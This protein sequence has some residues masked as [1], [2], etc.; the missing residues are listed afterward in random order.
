MDGEV[1]F[2]DPRRR[3]AQE[4]NGERGLEAVDFDI[5]EAAPALVVADN[6]PA[7]IGLA[8]Q[9]V[10]SGLTNCSVIASWVER[11]VYCRLTIR[12]ESDEVT[13]RPCT[14]MTSPSHCCS[15]ARMVNWRAAASSGLLGAKTS[16]WSP[17]PKSGR[18]TRSPGLVMSNC[19][20]MSRT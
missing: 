17:L 20:I 1:V 16:C 2:G 8:F 5:V 11:S 4:E 3:L 14:S 6:L 18:L 15:V 19:S 12:L 7:Q 10:H 9:C 13:S